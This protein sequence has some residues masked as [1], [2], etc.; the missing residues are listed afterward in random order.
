M[1]W[2]Y[3]FCAREI[4]KLK[5]LYIFVV[6]AI[7]AGAIYAWRGI[8]KPDKFSHIPRVKVKRGEFVISIE[9]VGIIKARKQQTIYAPF[10]GKITRIADDGTSV[11]KG[12]TVIWLDTEEVEKN[13]D[14]Q[15]TNLKSTKT[16]LERT[17][18][19][20]LKGLRNN[21]LKVESAAA[22]LEFARLKLQDVN[23]K[24]ETAQLLVD[25]NIIAKSQVDTKKLNVQSEKFNTLNTDLSFRKDMK[26]KEGDEL[27]RESELGK[28]KIRSLKANR[29]IDEAHKKIKEAE[30]KAPTDGLFLLTERYDWQQGSNTKPQAGDH[31][32][33]RRALAEIPDLSSLVILSQ[34]SEEEFAKV[35]PGQETLITIDA[36]P[37]LKLK[38]N[39]T[40]IGTVAIPRKISPAGSILGGSEDTGQK[41]FEVD[42]QSL[43]LDPRLRPGFT[44]NV[45]II[46]QTLQDAL[47]LPIS[48]VFRKEGRS[49][50]YRVTKKGYATQP[51]TLGR[52]NR[53]CVEILSGL[54]AGDA[55]FTKDLGQLGYE[56]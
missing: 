27:T 53:E 41:V 32:W 29:K 42:L 19:Q 37:D 1:G 45:S 48:A 38:A 8:E 21:T 52:R 17:I 40:R 24:L 55:V 36:F 6:I 3:L 28:V 35:F 12:Q 16:E 22:E 46:L 5:K 9:E 33:R 13:L 23:R 4:G 15:I 14:E 25:K 44:A 56:L 30:I 20:L 50:V 31:V 26:E 7:I 2:N 43:K 47:T 11:T 49:V 18:E 51:L 54:K 39:I 34:V 10:S